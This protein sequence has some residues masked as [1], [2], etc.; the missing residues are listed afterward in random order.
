VED[1]VRP[2]GR[3]RLSM[4]AAV[5]LAAERGAGGGFFFDF[6]GTLAPIRED[7]EVVEPVAGAVEALG[8]LAAA[9][10]RVDI[11]SARPVDFL[12]R[13][14]GGAGALT[15]HGLY[16][17]ERQRDGLEV[18]TAA[19]ALPFVPLVAELAERA[20]RE[21]P[22]TVRIEFKRLSVALHYRVEPA[23]AAEVERWS[24]EQAARH[25]LVAQRGRMVV[26]L[27]PPVRR[28]KGDVVRDELDGL[29][30][31]WYFG[32]D[33]SDLEAFAALA[34]RE[35]AGDGFVGVRVAVANAET[36]AALAGEADFVVDSPE[37]MPALLTRLTAAIG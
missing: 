29:S 13:R 1:R 10:R 22:P 8:R 27:K 19:E 37:D 11:V 26:E 30:S 12:R 23:L 9:A 7:P 36:G 32:D 35:A 34:E 25:G 28:G 2:A 20:R 31:A 16:G 17:L 4:D 18:E 5:A 3:A 21:L 15:L 33:L 14:L 6:D 24:G